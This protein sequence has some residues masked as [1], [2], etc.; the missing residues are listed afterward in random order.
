MEEREKELRAKGYL[1]GLIQRGVWEL[2]SL[3]DGTW[4]MG[5]EY[6]LC[7]STVQCSVVN[8]RYRRKREGNGAAK[9]STK[10]RS[11]K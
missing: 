1:I 8:N 6:M 7:I 9:V 10:V 3:V 2:W 11:E 4:G 5:G